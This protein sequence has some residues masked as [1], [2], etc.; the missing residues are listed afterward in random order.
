MIVQDYRERLEFGVRGKGE[1]GEGGF[2]RYMFRRAEGWLKHNQRLVYKYS[3]ALGTR[4]EACH[5]RQR[6]RQKDAMT[7]SIAAQQESEHLLDP[8]GDLATRQRL[9]DQARLVQ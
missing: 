5:T 8:G 7:H 4:R 9:L 3:L 2:P 6:L 1:Q